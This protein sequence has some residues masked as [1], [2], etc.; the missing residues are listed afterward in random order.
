MLAHNL[1]IPVANNQVEFN[2]L[3]NEAKIIERREVMKNLNLSKIVLVI[4]AVALVGIA[5]NAFAGWG[6]GWHHGPGWHRGGWGMS[7]PG[8]GY[9]LSEDEIKALEKE[10]QAFFSETESIRQALYAKDLELR[11]ELAKETP[12]AKKAA[13]LQ[14]EISKLESQLDQKRIDHMIKMRKLNPNAGRGRGYMGGGAMGYGPRYGDGN[15]W[16]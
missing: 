7:G 6:K 2:S 4:G 16:R 10:R 3:L 12:D 8:Y 11:S 5:V 14:T 13:R 9:N 1:P 15:C